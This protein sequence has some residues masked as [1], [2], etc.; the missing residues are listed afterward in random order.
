MNKTELLSSL[1]K[2]QELPNQEQIS[3]AFTNLVVAIHCND[4]DQVAINNYVSCLGDVLA[5]N[6]EYLEALLHVA[7]FINPN[8]LLIN[9]LRVSDFTQNALPGNELPDLVAVMIA[10][11]L[12]G[13][14]GFDAILNL[15]INGI[16]E[17]PR[18]SISSMINSAQPQ[19]Q[20]ADP[21]KS[22][23]S[24]T[25]DLEKERKKVNDQMTA[26]KYGIPEEEQALHQ[27]LTSKP[28]LQDAL[29]TFSNKDD[30]N[31]RRPGSSNDGSNNNPGG[32]P[33]DSSAS[34]ASASFSAGRQT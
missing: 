26:T 32:S 33:G 20:V 6:T 30:K 5:G 12:Q 16:G 13:V 10:T 22:P 23:E 27:Q 18:N 17:D 29:L 19:Q 25:R 7:Q 11:S 24:R 21:F 3:N 1:R 9:Q 28:S 14:G 8:Q 15:V 34:G 2:I 4:P 31:N